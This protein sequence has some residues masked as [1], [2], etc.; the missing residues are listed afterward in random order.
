MYLHLCAIHKLYSNRQRTMHELG[1]LCNST[2]ELL[3]LN[4]YFQ[5]NPSDHS[6]VH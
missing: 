2:E 5:D 4:Q 6:T 3:E 1:A